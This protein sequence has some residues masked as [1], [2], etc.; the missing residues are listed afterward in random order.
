MKAT[1]KTARRFA[2]ATLIAGLAA[3]SGGGGSHPAP[4]VPASP[5]GPN[6]TT[7]SS[8][9]VST[10][11]PNAN[12][13]ST[14][15]GAPVSDVSLAMHVIVNMKD[16]AGLADYAR[17]ANDPSD[18]RYRQW[19]TATQIGDRFGATPGDYKTVANYFST[20]G[21]RVG[22]YK[23]R[24]SLIVSGTQANFERA[25]GTTF[26]T[27]TT[28]NGHTLYGPS[29]SIHLSQ[30]LPV[31]SIDNAVADPQRFSQQMVRAGGG[32]NNG[33][34]T[35]NTPQQ[36]AAAFDFNGAYNDG[37]TGT[38]INL[39]II[40]T[41]PILAHDLTKFKQ[42]YGW[43]GSATVTQINAQTHAASDTGNT[44]PTATPPPT[45]GPCNGP[46]PGCNPEDFE[47]QI[48]TE[49]ASLAKDANILFYLAYVPKDCGT[50]GSATC[51]PNPTTGLGEPYIGLSEDDTSLQQAIDDNDN[52]PSAAGN[53]GPD[54]LSLSY[55]G[56]ERGYGRFVATNSLGQWDPTALKPAEFAALTAQGVAVF[57]SSG[58]AGAQ[59]CARPR[60]AGFID[61]LCVSY[62]SG[63]PN[64][65]SVGGVTTPI[66]NAGQ[67]MGPITAW[68]QQTGGGTGGASGGGV[69]L[70]IPRPN[71]QTGAGLVAGA[72]RLQ[73]DASLLGDPITGAA[74]IVNS[75]F[76]LQVLRFG[77][78]S[79]AAPEMAA[80]WALVLDA[81]NKST[82]CKGKGAGPRPFRLGN[83]APYF[84][85]IY[86]NATQYPQTMYDVTFGNNGVTGCAQQAPGCTAPATP[87]PGYLSGVGYDLVT[88][89]GVP[90]GRHLIT[91]VVGV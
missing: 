31:S 90:F 55:G 69:S 16:A 61:S 38:G 15:K 37:Y 50:P 72:T 76:G 8:A 67:L 18:A 10:L 73:P 14:T 20:Y 25:L 45:T 17:G 87:D 34:V 57:V 75:D 59:E 79:V 22:G 2:A 30:A 26:V 56:S 68:G 33:G 46:L 78:T 70:F 3:C 83:A 19:L 84:Y 5:A 28:S 9:L 66:N 48:D 54:I 88:G 36:I 43:G 58:D 35:G 77:G 40:G 60:V 80:M 86:N 62:P 71:W 42:I 6:N 51:T 64:V 4:A 63:D 47:A 53:S 27:Y 12:L 11:V 81:C 85:R 49:Q 65:M 1:M 32:Q 89:V 21:L 41:G 7:T 29:G 23:A 74:T 44:S 39:G 82:A 13:A 52:Y 91:A 24:L